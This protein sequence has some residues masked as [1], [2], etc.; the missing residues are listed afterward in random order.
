MSK[1]E[2]IAP[3]DVKYDVKSSGSSTKPCG[4]PYESVTLSERVSL[5][6]CLM[7]IFQIKRK[8]NLNL[9]MRH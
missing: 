6:Y 9:N 7:P 5:T 2:V 1:L 4:T 8:P 3:S